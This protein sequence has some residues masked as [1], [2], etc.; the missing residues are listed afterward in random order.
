MGR[1]Y[2]GGRSGAWR[3]AG[4]AASYAKAPPAWP[5]CGERPGGGRRFAARG[6]QVPLRKAERRRRRRLRRSREAATSPP[7]AGQSARPS[8]GPW[9]RASAAA[10]AAHARRGGLGARAEAAVEPAGRG[11]EPPRYPA[12]PLPPAAARQGLE[13]AAARARGAGDM[14][15]RKQSNPRQIKR[16]SNFARG[17]RQTP[18]GA[19]PP[20]AAP[21]RP[22]NPAAP[23]TFTPRRAPRAECQARRNLI[24]AGGQGP[25]VSAWAPRGS[26]PQ[27]G[28]RVPRAGRRVS[29]GAAPAEPGHLA[30]CT[31]PASEMVRR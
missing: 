18:A 8:A 5:A 2:R 12:A 30:A 6:S 4:P 16:E 13:A 22:P 11:H 7:P 21:A 20:R 26:G 3:E 15:R 1:R 25:R 23:A 29:G 24:S 28:W 17:A 9:P 19:P 31:S 27:R 10:P 14:S